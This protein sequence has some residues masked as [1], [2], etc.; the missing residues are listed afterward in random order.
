MADT[1]QDDTSPVQ[2][3]AEAFLATLH[4]RR[5][6]RAFQARPVPRQVLERILEA[7]IWAPSASNVQPW[8]FTVLRGQRK[9]ELADLLR[10]CVDHLR[11][12]LNPVLWVHRSGLRRSAQI[13]ESSAATIIAWATL[14]PDGARLRLVA[15]GDLIPLFSWT[16]VVQSVAAAVQ[17]LLLAAHALGLG[18]VWMGYPSLAGPQIGEWL[19]ED[20]ELM[21]TV[22]LGYPAATPSTGKRRPLRDVVR[23]EG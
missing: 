1:P 20:G 15:R 18:A 10:D 19:G 9:Q 4:S 5:S 6:I 3:E 13:I 22:A 14:T 11:P 2:V 7:A 16:M 21:A 23:W 12:G 17:N 8:R